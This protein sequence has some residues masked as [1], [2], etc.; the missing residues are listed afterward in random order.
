MIDINNRLCSIWNGLTCNACYNVYV[1][2]EDRETFARR[3]KAEGPEFYARGLSALR[4][5][6]LN[7]IETGQLTVKARFGPKRESI[8]PRFLYKAWKGVFSDEGVFL[9]HNAD[10]GAVD[11]LN[12]LTAVFGKIEGG[13]TPQSEIDVINRF[14]EVER[15]LTT[16]K[17]DLDAR[18][19][20]SS[21]RNLLSLAERLIARVLGSV[22]PR[23]IE[24][25]H[26]AGVSSD[27]IP[28]WK[29]YESS[30]WIEKIHAYWDYTEYFTL[31]AAHIAATKLTSVATLISGN[32]AIGEYPI[33]CTGIE[34]PRCDQTAKVLIVPKNAKGPRLISCEPSTHMYVQQGLMKLLVETVERSPLTRR[35]VHF[36]DQSHN[37][38]AARIGSTCWANPDVDENLATIDLKDASD[39]IRLDI[40]QYL[41][42]CEWGE[43]LTRA[44]TE[45][46]VLPSGEVV[47]MK[48][49]APMGSACCFPVMA[50]VIWAVLSVALPPKTK[51]LVYGDDIVIPS[52]FAARAMEALESI[53]LAVNRTKSF[54]K[55]PF[56]E[57]CGK[58]YYEG[59][60]VTPVYLRSMPYD[61]L[62]SRDTLVSFANNLFAKFGDEQTWLTERLDRVFGRIPRTQYTTEKVSS[63]SFEPDKCSDGYRGD[64]LRVTRA[65]ISPLP[66]VLWSWSPDNSGLKSR[67]NR[68]D[69]YKKDYLYRVAKPVR[70]KYAKHDWSQ[71]FRGLVNPNPLRPLGVDTVANRVSYEKRWVQL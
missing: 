1:D 35:S 42:P 21:V 66:G 65:P 43:A 25:K 12:Q 3:T 48:K 60:D 47:V 24:P 19:G 18:V 49:H 7:G 6:L 67:R 63:A 33:K 41:F 30:V 29:R 52:R 39:R 54:V 9:G 37:Q 32:H 56:R 70:V 58:E 17:V 59:T 8:L 68:C 26:S 4:G 51:I 23:V 53:H 55:G 57:S 45:R 62:D 5:D 16:R 15:E 27:G 34:A 38:V 50:I 28:P 40:V 22:N 44:R 31:G 13:H 10:I 36:T 14:K 2:D 61:D 20:V 69:P 46:T 71:L 11:C 64:P